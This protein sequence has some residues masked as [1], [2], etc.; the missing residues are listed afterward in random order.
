VGKTELDGDVEVAHILTISGEKVTTEDAIEL[1]TEN[2][3]KHLGAAGLVDF[4]KDEEFG[5]EDPGPEPV[6]VFLV[7]CF[8][9]IDSGFERKVVKE[10]LVW[11]L[12]GIPD[13][14][15]DFAEI[16]AGDL[17]T[18]DI[19][20]KLLDGGVGSMADV[21]HVGNERC[22]TSFEE[23]LIDDLI[24]ERHVVNL[25]AMGAPDRV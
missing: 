20:D 6:A 22:D 7:A 13:L 24:R 8:V 19:A 17:F 9:D 14:L 1:F 3:D 15:H 10:F 16:A 18:E 2:V 12:Q 25:L 21:F 5:L 4:E 11:R 23:A